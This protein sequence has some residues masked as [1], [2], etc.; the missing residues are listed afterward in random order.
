MEGLPPSN[1]HSAADAAVDPFMAWVTQPVD[2]NRSVGDVPHSRSG[3]RLFMVDAI[4]SDLRLF[5][6]HPNAIMRW[7]WADMG[8]AMAD[9]RW[10]DR[11][12]CCCPIPMPS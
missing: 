12:F 8:A 3:R 9:C 10:E 4:K 2:Y 5:F 6:F 11:D 1:A 7:G